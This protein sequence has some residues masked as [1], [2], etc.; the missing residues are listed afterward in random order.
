LCQKLEALRRQAKTG[1]NVGQKEG[2]SAFLTYLLSQTELSL[3]EVNSNC[4]DLFIAAAET[5]LLVQYNTIQFTESSKVTNVHA[6][7]RFVNVKVV[8]N[9]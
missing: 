3:E 1:L 8:S 2:K 7:N 4:V 5:V 9:N 6:R